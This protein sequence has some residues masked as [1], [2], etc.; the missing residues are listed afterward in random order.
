M[1]M[2]TYQEQFK[3]DNFSLAGFDDKGIPTNAINHD[4]DSEWRI[5]QFTNWELIQI[6]EKEIEE[7]YKLIDAGYYACSPMAAKIEA[8]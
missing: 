3:G 7:G 2:N 8:K 6:S 5:I 1:Y 4:D